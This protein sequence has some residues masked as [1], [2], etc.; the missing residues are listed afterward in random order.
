M[1]GNSPAPRGEPSEHFGLSG[2]L[3]DDPEL[4]G[5]TPDIA[6]GPVPPWVADL[7]PELQSEY[8]HHRASCLSSSLYRQRWYAARHRYDL[9]D[10]GRGPDEIDVVRGPHGPVLHLWWD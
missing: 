2:V 4:L 7:D 8:Y 1:R 10:A 9:R 6:V 5:F 3:I